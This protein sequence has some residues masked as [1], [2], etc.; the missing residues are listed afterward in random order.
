MASAITNSNVAYL[1]LL[2]HLHLHPVTVANYNNMVE[3]L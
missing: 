2:K 3:S 1:A